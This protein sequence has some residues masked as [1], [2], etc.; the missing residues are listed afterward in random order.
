MYLFNGCECATKL[1][2][3]AGFME[4]AQTKALAKD[5]DAQQEAAFEVKTQSWTEPERNRYRVVLFGRP[6]VEE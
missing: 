2:E 3:T 1:G 5:W 4:A 6:K